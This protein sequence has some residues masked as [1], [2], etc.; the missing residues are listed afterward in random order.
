[1]DKSLGSVP[2]A[3]LVSQAG[4]CLSQN[5]AWVDS[6]RGRLSE[7]S[8]SQLAVITALAEMMISPYWELGSALERHAR[9]LESGDIQI[10]PSAEE[11]QR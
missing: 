6:V 3:N 4:E 1:M 10:E 9:S 5:A 8:E 2:F 11:V 7:L